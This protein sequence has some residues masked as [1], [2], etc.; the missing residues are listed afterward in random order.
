[1]EMPD[2]QDTRS[3]DDEGQPA[4]PPEIA[5][6]KRVLREVAETREWEDYDDPGVFLDQLVPYAETIAAYEGHNDLNLVLEREL[7]L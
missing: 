4:D 6:A 5:N 7:E 1:M 2:E 3:T